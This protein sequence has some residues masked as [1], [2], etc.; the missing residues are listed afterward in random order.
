MGR[1]FR[2][3][4]KHSGSAL[5]WQH[6]SSNLWGQP[7]VPSDMVPCFRPESDR[8]SGTP[9]LGRAEAG[10]LLA[11]ILPSGPIAYPRPVLSDTGPL[12]FGAPFRTSYTGSGVSVSGIW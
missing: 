1:I 5:S 12:A 3:L 10:K 11:S 8:G 9:I 2:C 6:R 4:A 7:A